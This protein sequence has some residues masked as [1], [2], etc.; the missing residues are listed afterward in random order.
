MLINVYLIHE[1]MFEIG[2][3]T[4]IINFLKKIKEEM[5]QLKNKKLK[6]PTF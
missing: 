2:Y 3:I 6:S 1:L 5:F 4:K